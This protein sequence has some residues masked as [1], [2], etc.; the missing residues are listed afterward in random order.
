MST[1]TQNTDRLDLRLSRETKARWE[2][3]AELAGASSVAGF[4]K[5]VVTERA[6][7]LIREH[8]TLTLTGEES[9][10]LHAFL[11]EPAGEPTPA[12]RRAAAR[13][14]ELFGRD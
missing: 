10:W 9:A 13:R 5:M 2:R 7:A 11:G 1:T 12:M 8:D 6:D 14:R 4:V 3:A